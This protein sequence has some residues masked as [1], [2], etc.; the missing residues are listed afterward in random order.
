M[1]VYVASYFLGGELDHAS[2]GELR[3]QLGDVRS[4]HMCAENFPVARIGNDLDETI[5]L[6]EA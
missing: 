4:H 6:A 3:Q 5:P 2:Q 1:R